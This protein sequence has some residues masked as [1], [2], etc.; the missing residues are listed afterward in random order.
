MR[1]SRIFSLSVLAG[2]MLTLFVPVEAQC[3]PGLH[4]GIIAQIVPLK[5]GY[6][7]P[8][9][10]VL[11][12]LLLNDSDSLADTGQHSW[13]IMIDG[14]PLPNP[15][16]TGGILVPP[17][18]LQPGEHREWGIT[19]PLSDYFPHPGEYRV[20][21]RGERF[22]SPTITIKISDNDVAAR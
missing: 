2:A 1:I 11:S 16:V 4:A 21:W 8:A 7:M 5:P 22:Q 15:K 20:S 13:K 18:P 17:G 6:S 19:F 14:V 3:N 12:F 10:V 9:H